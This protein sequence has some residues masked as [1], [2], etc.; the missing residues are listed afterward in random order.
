MSTSIFNPSN[1]NRIEVIPETIKTYENTMTVL[2]DIL[3]QKEIE[4][5][6]ALNH[7]VKSESTIEF[8]LHLL[9]KDT[10]GYEIK[11]L[12][13]IIESQNRDLE[14]ERRYLRD[15]LEHSEKN[16]KRKLEE[17]NFILPQSSSAD[18]YME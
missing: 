8:Y 13:A 12:K 6:E 2:Y 10:L 1:V 7:F 9:K 16:K 14:Q 3:K 15:A 17:N 5:K 18:L 4:E 11:Q